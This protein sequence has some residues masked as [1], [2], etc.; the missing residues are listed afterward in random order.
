MKD[1]K[2]VL[3]SQPPENREFFLGKTF[4]NKV[5]SNDACVTTQEGIPYDSS[6]Y[7]DQAE[8]SLRSAR[9]VLDVLEEY[10]APKKVIDLGCGLG[11]WLFPFH[12]KGIDVVGVDGDSVPQSRLYIPS[13]KF[14]NWD[15]AQGAEVP[16]DGPFDLAIS[17][18][19]AE[20]L[21]EDKASFLVDQLTRLSDCVLFCAGIPGQGGA[22]H[23]NE[24]WQSYWKERFAKKQY[25]CFDLIRPKIWQN[26]KVNYRYRQGALLYIKKKAAKTIL[27]EDFGSFQPEF[28]NLVHPAGYQLE[29]KRY[30]QAAERCSSI[31]EKLVKFG[32][33]EE[34]LKPL[35][36]EK[37]S[38]KLG[39]DLEQSHV[40]LERLN[41]LANQ[42]E[43]HKQKEDIGSVE[44]S[45][46]ATKSE[47][48]CK[49]KE[50]E[51]KLLKVQQELVRQ[52]DEFASLEQQFVSRIE[53]YRR[54]TS[55]LEHSVFD[56]R[57]SV[58]YRIGQAFVDIAIRPI[59]GSIKLFPRLF[60]IVWSQATKKNDTVASRLQPET[61]PIEA[62]APASPS[63]YKLDKRPR[64]VFAITTYNRLDYL[65]D[66]VESFLATCNKNYDWLVIVADDGSDESV[67]QYLDQ[68]D[69]PFDIY[70]IRNKR[71]YC[72]GQTN[73]IFALS[74]LLGFDIGFKVD[75]DVL[76]TRKGWDDLYLNAMEKSNYQHLCYMNY[77]HFLWNRKREDPDYTMPGKVAD[78][79]GACEAI[80]NAYKCMGAFFTFT[81]D[82]IDKVGSC[83]ESNFPIRG[84]WHIDL[85][86]RCCRAGFNRFDTFF[87][88]KG[89]NDY[90]E[91][92]NN[93][94]DDYRCSI[95]W[96]SEYASTK[97]PKEL[98]KR[99]A[100]IDDTSRVH[101][102]FDPS[103]VLTPVSIN[104][105]F[106]KIFV[107]NLERRSDRWTSAMQ[108]AEQCGMKVD[109]FDAV[110][111]KEEPFVSQWQEYYDKGTCPRQSGVREIA[112]SK[113]YYL[114][115]E[116]DAARI[117]FIEKRT[118]KKAISSP[119]AWGYLK[120]MERMLEHAIKND[121]A[122]ILVL[123]DDFI[124]HNDFQKQFTL[125]AHQV[126]MDW[127]VLKLGAI[128]YEWGEDWIQFHS[129]NAYRCNGS[130]VASHAVGL[131]RPAYEELLDYTRRLLLPYDEGALHKLMHNH[132]E[133]CFV[134]YPNLFIQD[135]SESDINGGV[136]K[137][138]GAKRDNI[139]R[140]NLDDY[141]R[142]LSCDTKKPS[143]SITT[144]ETEAGRRAQ[145]IL[146]NDKADLLVV[147]PSGIGNMLMFMPAMQALREKYPAANISA[148]CFSPEAA[149]IE[150]LVDEVIV[151]KSLRDKTAALV[152]AL[153]G[154]TF[155]VAIYPPFTDVGKMSDALKPIAKVHVFHPHVDFSKKHEVEHNNDIARML[156]IT[157]TIP[158][159]RHHSEDCALLDQFK[160][161]DF[162]CIHIGACGSEQMQKKKWPLEYWSQLLPM[163]S[164]KYEVLI[165]GGQGELK[166][167]KILFSMLPKSM[168]DRVHVLS[169]KLTLAQTARAI[170]MCKTLIS[171]D[172]GVM[173]LGAFVGAKIVAIFG[174][175]TPK[176]NAPWGNPANF[177]IV[178]PPDTVTCAP[179][180]LNCGTQLLSCKDQKCL[181]Q[182]TP[183]MINEAIV[184]LT[185]D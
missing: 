3:D 4:I 87:D 112:C 171:T 39:K 18:D 51:K 25:T 61:I 137:E 38:E 129:K 95:P 135:V 115:Y 141:S 140:W 17:L 48:L 103:S 59:T 58:S 130:S 1:R 72:V 36:Q 176:K 102:P 68:I 168:K 161:T 110:D 44:H 31:E 159:Y 23:I 14:V 169:G 156:G 29:V 132:S 10:L 99:Y 128:Q 93:V 177:R 106:D 94:V 149:I 120:T 97:D 91:L 133:Q 178:T 145:D 86:I 89:S 65:K 183:S 172:S 8:K 121:Y 32:L 184:S 56:L 146:N 28:I 116:D 27:G 57:K 126:P 96:N 114:N 78:E 127:L 46:V 166:D 92:Q 77:N 101:L 21:P 139:Y 117:H 124:C 173:H 9:I 107:L 66:C 40:E 64:L 5:G 100:L 15:L 105:F 109:R 98:Q 118:G 119:G 22:G 47:A 154:R 180:F 136:Q 11:T 84:Q 155:D 30:A 45:S 88:A 37:R 179:C 152:Q 143:A 134:A 41:G 167:A 148:A 60:N 63:P 12:E 67:A 54:R 160:N 6:F 182:I 125:F 16:V 79:S 138:I 75:D 20:H 170:E 157:G 53:G 73:T 50:V 70:F 13:N 113:D 19:V 151:I 49:I 7:Y 76:F 147:K 42:R 82:L 111:G 144:D 185:C 34:Q 90:I 108:R 43:V 26:E 175:T 164:D 2:I 69:S 131:R 85:S 174:P 163:V 142:I 33:L 181:H 71:R 81:P 35:E 165:L 104:E 52:K 158:P 83:D 24:Q 62:N 162:I 55:Q 80:C 74:Q 122:S 123:D 150:R 153:D